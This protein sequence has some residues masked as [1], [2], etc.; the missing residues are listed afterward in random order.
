MEKVEKGVS[1]NHKTSF[2]QATNP[3]GSYR[4]Q[5]M[6]AWSGEASNQRFQLELFALKVVSQCFLTKP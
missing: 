4:P 5:N 1:K 3:L 6:K 2:Q